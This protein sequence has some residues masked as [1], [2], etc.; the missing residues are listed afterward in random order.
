M[1]QFDFVER[2]KTRIDLVSAYPL[3]LTDS[4][5]TEIIL[6]EALREMTAI[7]HGLNNA[8]GC[9]QKQLEEADHLVSEMQHI[10]DE[11]A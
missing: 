6:M 7:A 10:I 8:L 4:T 1:K 2:N 11:G 5:E 3:S 9:T